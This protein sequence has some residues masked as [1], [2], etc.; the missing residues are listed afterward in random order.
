MPVRETRPCV[1]HM[2]TRL[3]R[4][5]GLI[6]EPVVSLPSPRLANHAA[7]AAPVPLLEPPPYLAGLYGL[8]TRPFKVPPPLLPTPY[9]SDWFS[10]ASTM[11]PAARRRAMT[12]ASR[13]G[14]D[15]A[16]GA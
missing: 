12:N 8:T 6:T 14:C 7:M 16:I 2:P 1:G 4:L 10:F 3:L 9:Q 11:T 5:L 15:I 13:S